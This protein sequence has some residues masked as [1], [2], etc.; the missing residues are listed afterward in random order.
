MAITTVLFDLDGTLLPMDLDVFIKAYLG[1]LS[2][3]MIP[4]GY[5]QKKLI[6]SLWLG[7]IAMVKNNGEKTNEAAFWETVKNIYGE[8]IYQ[9]QSLFDEFYVEEYNTLSQVCG[10]DPAAAEIIASLKAK[11]YR[12]IL[13]T[14]PLFP[15][16][17]TQWRIRW[18]GL[19]PQDFELITSFENSSYCK[20]NTDYYRSILENIG[21]S[22]EECLMVGN[23]VSEDM[24]AS[25]LGME[26]FLLTN[27]LI[28]KENTDIS[29]YPNG[30]YHALTSFL[31]QL[32]DRN[33]N[34]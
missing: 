11:G 33:S 27:C 24:V 5:D 3:W 31:N 25:K 1:K 12:L 23:D 21:V 29:Q 30:D 26:V 8:K 34:R 2:H 16:A 17:A 6:E 15:A 20:P 28:N 7:N 22:A 19:N 14:N 4:Y 10:Y 32:P 13:A 9:D 18:A